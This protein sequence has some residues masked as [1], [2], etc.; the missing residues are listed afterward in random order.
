MKFIS[1]LKDV[2]SWG[3]DIDRQVRKYLYGL[4]NW[5]RGNYCWS[6]ESGRYFGDKGLEIQKTRCVPI[7]PKVTPSIQDASLRRCNVMI[8][9]IEDLELAD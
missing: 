5:A 1:S 4:A 9:L 6:F 2:P 3:H 7:L 8:P